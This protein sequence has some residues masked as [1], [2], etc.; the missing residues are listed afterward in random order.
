MGDGGAIGGATAGNG[1]TPSRAL[2][3]LPGPRPLPLLGNVHQFGSVER[4]HTKIEEWCD[5]YGPIFRIK[6]GP[7]VMIG[8]GDRAAIDEILRDRPERYARASEERA[9]LSEMRAPWYPAD[10]D[11][12]K[13]GLFAV[14][15]DEWRKQRPRVLSVLNA[16]QMPRYFEIVRT[17]GER[18][19]GRMLEA[20]RAGSSLEIFD[21]LTSYTVDATTALA[22]GED[23]NTLERGDGELQRSLKLV[24]AAIMRRLGT[25]VPYWRRFKLPA[26]RAVDRALEAIYRIMEDAQERTRAR[27]AAEP[28]RREAPANVLEG[29]VAAQ[30]EHPGFSDEE[31]LFNLLSILIGGEDTTASTL[32]WTAWL[33]GPRPDVQE[34]LAAEAAEAFG[35]APAATAYE[36]LD[37]LPYTVA[38]L[39]ES[40]RLKSVFPV[41][42]G[43]SAS[44]PVRASVPA[45]TSPC[46]SRRRRSRCSASTSSSSSTSPAGRC[47]RSARRRWRR[48]A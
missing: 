31:I 1:A 35:G 29:M 38:V 14:E 18:L 11:R 12:V 9:I 16:N 33:L 5:L 22:L 28:E 40:M 45:A 17:A 19:R 4:M 34:R 32:G 37:R 42:R 23:P 26:D 2:K 27:L 39:R 10:G 20:A 15:G 46:S 47:T 24:I 13:W 30:E 21:L 25:P 6:A 44:A 3:D 7:R 48:T 36:Q 41:L 43:R 8:V